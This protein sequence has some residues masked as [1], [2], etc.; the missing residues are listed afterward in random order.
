MVWDTEG[1]QRKI[2]HAAVREFSA[3]GP[4]GTTIERIAKTAGVNKERIYNYFG[5]KR[6]LFAIVLREEMAKIARAVPITS[7]ATEDIGE[8][9]GRLYDYHREHPELTRLIRWEGLVFDGQVPEEDKRRE[10]YTYKVAAVADGQKQGKITADIAAD[11]LMFLVFS[12]AFTW[13]TT[14]HMARMMSAEESEAEHARRRASV[15]CAARRL[16]ATA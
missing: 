5:N 6:E 10:Y 1:T 11:H 9:A 15:V 3:R 2:I 16:A 8:Y 4:D 7:F 12:L 14:P 13:S